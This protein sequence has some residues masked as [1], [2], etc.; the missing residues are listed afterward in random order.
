MSILC[1]SCKKEIDDS[2]NFCPH[3]GHKS[4]LANVALTSTQKRRIYIASFFL[5]PFGLYWFFKYFRDDKP[6]NRK[7][8]YISLIFTIVPLV[9]L[10]II[11]GK[12]IN[13][14]SGVIDMYETN[15]EVYSELGY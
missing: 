13:S 8:A 7:A 2:D 15:L 4:D 12:Y 6:E 10:V 11:I 5:T 1:P 3:C 14:L 9:L